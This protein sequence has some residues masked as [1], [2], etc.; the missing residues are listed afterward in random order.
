MNNRICARP[1]L[2]PGEKDP[3]ARGPWQAVYTTSEAT[4]RMVVDVEDFLW[5]ERFSVA[6]LNQIPMQ[7]V[8]EAR[9]TFER[10]A[11]SSLR[12]CLWV[13]WV[14]DRVAAEA[15]GVGGTSDAVPNLR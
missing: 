5:R 6:S 13:N 3:T 9:P 7:R 14:H 11:K 12:A 1:A 15:A 2:I 10:L 8:Q 4:A